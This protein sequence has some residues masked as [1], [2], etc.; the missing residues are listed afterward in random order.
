MFGGSDIYAYFIF[1]SQELGITTKRFYNVIIN[2]KLIT[3]KFN[4]IFYRRKE[5][6]SVKYF[7]SRTPKNTNL[8]NVFLFIKYL[9]VTTKMLNNYNIF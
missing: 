2:F 7:D 6:R 8:N 1:F 3:E 9:I 5:R 4:P